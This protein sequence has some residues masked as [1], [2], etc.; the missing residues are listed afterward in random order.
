MYPMR[1]EMLMNIKDTGNA[2][3]SLLTDILLLCLELFFRDQI[4]VLI[5]LLR[6]VTRQ[7]MGLKMVVHRALRSLKS[8]DTRVIIYIHTASITKINFQLQNL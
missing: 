5:L 7:L 6:K 4:L 2:R 8:R 3:V 1:K